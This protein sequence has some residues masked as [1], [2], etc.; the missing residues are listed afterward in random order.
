MTAP[1]LTEEQK[2]FIADI[3]AEMLIENEKAPKPK[4]IML[5]SPHETT[6]VYN[7]RLPVD[8]GEALI[9]MGKELNASRS[10]IVYH[11]LR[12]AITGGFIDQ[13]ESI[14]R[15]SSFQKYR[16]NFK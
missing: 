11:L 6:E 15:L 10:Y 7:H 12:Y 2:K 5:E 1:K 13:M 16:K 8:M 14:V 9:E 4:R 3:L